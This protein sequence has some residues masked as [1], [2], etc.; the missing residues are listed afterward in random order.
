MKNFFASLALLA[1]AEAA[2]RIRQPTYG[3]R[4]VSYGDHRS[5]SAG[6]KLVLVPKDSHKRIVTTKAYSP[7]K[8]PIKHVPRYAPKRVP[9]YHPK[10]SQ[11]QS[12][13]YDRKRVTHHEPVKIYRADHIKSKK[14]VVHKKADC[15][16]KSRSVHSHSPKPCYDC[17]RPT[18]SPSPK[19]CYDCKR[20]SSYSHKPAVK[21]TSPYKHVIKATPKKAPIYIS[22][23]KSDDALDFLWKKDELVKTKAP[24]HSHVIKKVPASHKPVYKHK[25]TP[26]YGHGKHTSSYGKHQV[27]DK[28]Y[29]K[30]LSY[31]HEKH[32]RDYSK[33]HKSYEREHS[34]GKDEGLKKI[35]HGHELVYGKGH[36]HGKPHLAHDLHR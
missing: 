5:Y 15:P 8:S 6:S 9:D 26:S 31:G 24:T 12:S 2:E 30:D 11:H 29:G 13:S 7:S 22:P 28:S 4:G 23:S 3:P 36:G 1:V 18:Y 17:K 19:P 14:P 21:S 33:S 27:H 20:P 32:E 16:K 25:P 10:Y 34:Y 35:E